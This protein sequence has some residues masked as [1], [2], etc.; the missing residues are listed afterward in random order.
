MSS[1]ENIP[2]NI[3]KWITDIEIHPQLSNLLCDS[4]STLEAQITQKIKL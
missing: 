3:S 2:P 4:R 1:G